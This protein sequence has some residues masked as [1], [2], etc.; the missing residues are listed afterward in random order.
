M[1]LA[2]P[3]AIDAI[4]TEWFGDCLARGF[5]GTRVIGLERGKTIHGT[6][7][8]IEF[9]LTYNAAGIDHGLPPSLWVKC[10]LETLIPGQAA[11]STVEAQFFRDLAPRLPVNLPRPYG[12]AIAPDGSSGIVIYEDLNLRPVSFGNQDTVVSPRAM[13]AILDML[14]ALHAAHWKSGDLARFD[15]LKPGGIIHSAGVVDQF[16]GFWDYAAA[17]PRFDQVPEALRDREVIGAAMKALVLDDVANPFCV[18]H[19]DPHIGNQFFDPDGRPGLLDWATVMHGHWAWDVSYAIISAQPV[20][21]RRACERDQLSHYLARLRS[22]GVAAPD[23]DEAWRDHARHAVWM[24]GFALCPV[25]LQPEEMCIR[26]AERVGAAMI[27]LGTIAA[28]L[29]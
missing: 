17:R 3:P 26:N 16:L 1:A 15:W 14:A 20:E 12:T 28:L 19:G 25:E 22:L 4:D 13:L 2:F 6:A 18:V 8:K 9:H 21:Q 24:F 27:D 5:P 10:G 23:F 11:H 7:T 29:G